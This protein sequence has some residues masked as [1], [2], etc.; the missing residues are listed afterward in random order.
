MKEFDLIDERM[1]ND[2]IVLLVRLKEEFVP[3][4]FSN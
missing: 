3:M 4:M 1:R 2:S